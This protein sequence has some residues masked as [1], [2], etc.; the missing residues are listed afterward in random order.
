MHV[1]D[2]Q[3]S[4]SVLAIG[5]A[6]SAI[7]VALSL[8][9]VDDASIPRIALVSSSFFAISLW[10]LPLPVPGTSIH[11]VLLG[12]LGLLL[13]WDTFLAIGMVLIFQA[14]LLGHGGV[15]A[16]GVNTLAMSLPGPLLSQWCRRLIDSP[17]PR[18]VMIGG[19]LVGSGSVLLATV[20]IGLAYLASQ[21]A[22][23]GY[24]PAYFLA[25]MP[26]MLV[27]GLVTASATLFLARVR[28]A[29]IGRPLPVA[30]AKVEP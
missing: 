4:G 19:F 13:G 24:L 11:L 23:M 22:F 17:H 14:L 18:W 25:N 6:A 29:T 30:S 15:T 26:L 7:G 12:L 1:G 9:R 20:L 2:A 21:R 16:I 27:E 8:R 28:P 5:A 3:L 10:H